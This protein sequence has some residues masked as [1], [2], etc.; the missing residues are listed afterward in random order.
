[1]IS[2]GR[3]GSL[4]AISISHPAA[5][6]PASA[7]GK[8]NSTGGGAGARA[9]HRLN[10]FGRQEGPNNTGLRDSQPSRGAGHEKSMSLISA[11]GGDAR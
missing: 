6:P 3:R 8:T 9:R 1:M 10:V 11:G 5:S 7:A 2:D 4:A